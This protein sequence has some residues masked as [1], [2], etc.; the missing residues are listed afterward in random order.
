MRLDQRWICIRSAVTL[1]R[2]TVTLYRVIR[3]VGT[4]RDGCGAAVP[5]RETPGQR[6]ADPLTGELFAAYG[7]KPRGDVHSLSRQQDA[8][9]TGAGSR[10]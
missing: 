2:V 9:A 5:L 8:A 4:G 3:A 10:R 1:Y 6:L 7:R